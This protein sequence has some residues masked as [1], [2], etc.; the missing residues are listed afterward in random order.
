MLPRRL[1]LAVLPLLGFVLAGFAACRS[2]YYG[3]LERVGV[4]K[5]DILADRVE[6][7]REAQ[8]QAQ[9]QFR[10]ALARFQAATGFRGGDL[11]DLYDDL[12]GELE[13]CQGEARDVSDRIRSIEQVAGDL[14][15][16]WEDEIGEMSSSDLRRRSASR[17]S[18]TRRRYDRLLAAMKRAEARMDPVLAAFR[19]QVLFL[20]HNLNAR[21]IASLED[22]VVEIE[23]DVAAL[24]REMEAA[25][26]E[27]DAFLA[28]MKD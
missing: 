15:A 19:D 20:K 14:F 27:A 9:E 8:Q 1:D 16:E 7:G 13:R 25:I 24:V 10:D 22:R 23:S 6:D 17:L 26:R 28:A 3:A 21:A 11:E 2:A 12:S 5:R 4:E 18:E